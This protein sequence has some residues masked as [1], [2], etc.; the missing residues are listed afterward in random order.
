MT[1]DPPLILIVEDDALVQLVAID[2]LEEQ[3]FRIQAASS[4]EEAVHALQSRRDKIDVL[5]TDI[6]LGP[7]PNGFEL[8]RRARELRPEIRI[9]YASGAPQKDRTAQEAPG[10][11]YLQKP[12]AIDQVVRAVSGKAG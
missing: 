2:L 8:A 1:D 10:S 9:V 7:G 5:F 4:A 11:A 12:Y 3:G 6:N